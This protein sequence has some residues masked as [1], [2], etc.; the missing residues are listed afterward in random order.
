M[1]ERKC[2]EC[3]NTVMGRIDKKF[4]SDQCRSTYY[5]RLH[6]DVNGYVRNIN[7]VLRKNRRILDELNPG[8]KIKVPARWLKERGFD[9]RYHTGT[10]KT[11]DGVVY[12]YCYEQ[13]YLPIEKNYVLLVLNQDFQTER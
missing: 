6:S 7:N 8:G 10:Y 12:Y 4:C 1:P 2:I 5:N 13:G 3:N 9:F 11:R